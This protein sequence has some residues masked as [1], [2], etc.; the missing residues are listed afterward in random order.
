MAKFRKKPLIVEAYRFDEH[1]WRNV[2]LEPEEFFSTISFSLSDEKIYCG[3]STG[4]QEINDGDWIVKN[5]KG[6]IYISRKD[7]FEMTYE[8][9]EE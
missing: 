4:A 8:G 3:T 9:V 5:E 1:L 2:R 7:F 6:D